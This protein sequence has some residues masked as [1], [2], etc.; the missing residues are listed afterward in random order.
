MDEQLKRRL[1]GATIVVLLM[2]IFVPMM[3]EDTA[4]KTTD[5]PEE[6]PAP[7][8][9]I[10]HRD[11][12]LPRSATDVV[13]AEPTEAKAKPAQSSGYQIVPLEDEAAKVTRTERGPAKPRDKPP[14]D[15][16]PVP[17]EGEEE[18]GEE[19]PLMGSPRTGDS[20]TVGG[21][22]PHDK[23]ALPATS[24]R[25]AANPEAQTAVR[26]APPMDPRL[27]EKTV[28]VPNVTPVENKR[29]AASVPPKATTE[30]AAA[31]PPKS[32]TRQE[33]TTTTRSVTASKPARTAT[34]PPPR[35]TGSIRAGE[36]SGSEKLPTSY[37]IQAGTFSSEANARALA[38]KLRKENLPASVRA[39]K[40][41]S[42]TVYKVT[43]GSELNQEQVQEMHR[44]VESAGGV[45][46][47]V[48]P[49]RR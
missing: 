24:P 33:G 42:G 37:A 49:Q 8:K 3:F 44:R 23:P 18:G 17:T 46:A 5:V 1:L 22:P 7:P 27:R 16:Q 45:R 41:S 35:S 21:K 40:V 20:S 26:S 25:P 39:T 6:I 43:V 2:V 36:G 32:S 15:E 34:V 48:V 4:E 13:P 19:V 31:T 10:E 30:R 28:A 14:A 9:G 11:I 12:E 47:I 29:R 38:E